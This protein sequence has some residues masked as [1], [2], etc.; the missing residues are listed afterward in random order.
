M[1][2]FAFACWLDERIVREFDKREGM[3]VSNS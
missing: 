1:L 2:N 3:S